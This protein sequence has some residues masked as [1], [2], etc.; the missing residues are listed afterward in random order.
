MIILMAAIGV[1][2]FLLEAA[3]IAVDLP[4]F[5]AFSIIGYG[6]AL[7]LR[8]TGMEAAGLTQFHET[9]WLSHALLCI[10]FFGAATVYFFRHIVV[11]VLSV[12]LRPER[13]SGQLRAFDPFLPESEEIT[14]RHLTWKDLLDADA[15]T[16]CGRCSSV[17]PATASGKALDPR[18]I[19]L[20]LSDLI[21]RQSHANGKRRPAVLDTTQDRELWDCTTC[22]ACVYECPVHIEVFD[23]IIDLR[24]N[25]VEIGLLPDGAGACLE[26]LQDRQNP[27]NY[28]PMERTVWAESL[29]L[30]TL[31]GSRTP[32]WVY[33]IGCAGAFDPSGQSISRSMVEILRKTGVDF[34]VLGSQERCTGDPARR[35]GD[36]AL[37]QEYKR[38]NLE[39]LRK[40][41][42][43][44]IVTHCPHC[45]N[46]FRNEY[47]AGGS[48]EF[49]VVHHSQFL[50]QLINDGKLR[51]NRRLEQK[52]TF[53][54]PC[55]LG[56][57]NGEYEAPRRVVD[58][59]P[60]VTRVE[61]PR[62]R[63]LSFC[64]GGGGGQMWLNSAGSQRIENVRLAEA[65]QTGAQLVASACPFCKVMF[66]SAST[67]ASGQEA[68]L[69]V[70]DISELVVEAMAG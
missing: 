3:R 37:F 4:R 27:W 46:T 2:G 44:R 39:T 54:D 68:Q 69:K 14:A 50:E 8:F 53:H 63:E 51:L 18:E 20:K 59:L 11:S 13:S 67:M 24:R 65:R 41:G 30:P 10:V 43:K 5:E 62:N 56:R 6:L 23:K 47:Q 1:T 17:C 42:V 64:C 48:P 34:A 61:M 52:V 9:V 22:G 32:E 16:A 19:V 38:Y 15:C 21:D 58:S 36:E 57:H 55:Y 7:A 35:L 60:G 26:S 70:K 45:L 25:R 49:E 66:E 31:N 33:W 12:A 40:C 29:R 28:P